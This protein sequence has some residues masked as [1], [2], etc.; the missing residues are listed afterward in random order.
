MNRLRSSS[1]RVRVKVSPLQPT[2]LSDSTAGSGHNTPDTIT[3]H[4]I[5]GKHHPT[6]DKTDH[7]RA[8]SSSPGPAYTFERRQYRLAI[9]PTG[10][11]VR[12]DLQLQDLNGNAAA[13]RKP[14]MPFFLSLSHEEVVATFHEIVWMERNRTMQSI[15][16]HSA[17]VKWAQVTGDHL[18]K[19]DRYI[20]IQPWENNRVRLRVPPGKVDYVNASPI[21]LTFTTPHQASEQQKREPGGNEGTVG[22]DFSR[23]DAPANY[24]AMQGPKQTTMDHVWRM[25]VEQLESPAVIVMLTETHEANMEKCYPYFPKSPDEA[26]MEVN[27]RDEFGDAFRA[28]VH[29][30]AIEQTEA[31][32]AIELRKLVIR[33][34]R[35]PEH[36]SGE[37]TD[38]GS[39]ST[40]VGASPNAKFP[41]EFEERIVWHFLYKKW[42]DFG[43]PALEDLDSFF[44]LMRLSREKNATFRNPRIVHCSAGVGRS[45]TFIALEHLMRELDAGVLEQ[46]DSPSHFRHK[47]TIACNSATI[48]GG[49]AIHNQRKAND[50]EGKMALGEDGITP[51]AEADDLIFN[52]VNELREQ[53]RSMVQAE[54]Q[55]FFIYDVM[56]KLWMDKYVSSAGEQTTTPASRAN[57]ADDVSGTENETRQPL[58]KR[59]KIDPFVARNK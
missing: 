4:Q 8:R 30:E 6:K 53:R 37:R 56:R 3:A 38:D 33:V 15:T 58:F 13:Y 10:R 47:G 57:G 28:R 48:Q 26:P 22:E 2:I 35:D 42:P 32:D 49:R 59:Q 45:G 19:L 23:A 7:K 16:H 55:F 31:G 12:A 40:K 21:T 54:P 36:E 50:S 41:L 34:L 43:V 11:G 20:N 51:T 52:T 46:W 29:C 25:V 39:L 24:I 1:H 44:T 17:D 14:E 27:E 9:S 18:K 5:Q